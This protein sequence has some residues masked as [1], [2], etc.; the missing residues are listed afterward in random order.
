MPRLTLATGAIVAALSAT[1]T[2]SAHAESQPQSLLELWKRIPPTP[3]TLEAANAMVNDAQEIPAITALLADLDAHGAA[4]SQTAT[5]ADA[6]IHERMTGGKSPE[7]AAAGAA[8]AAGIDVQRMQTDPAYAKEMEAKMRAMS[9]AELMA[10][11]SAMAQSMGMHATVAVYDPPEV[12]AAA[13]AGQAMM[14]PT[15]TTARLEAYTTRWLEVEK[16]TTAVNDAYAARYPKMSIG[17][18]GEGGGSP[19]CIAAR[20][21]YEAEMMPLLLARDAEVLKLEAV[22]LEQERTALAERVAAADAHLTAAQYGANSQELGNPMQILFLDQM[23]VEDMRTLTTR[24]AEVT[25]RAAYITHCG[26]TYLTNP[27]DCY[28]RQ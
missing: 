16:A 22:A 2:L 18:D 20:A 28:K 6:K 3:A 27:T 13:E 23:M 19:E 14:D 12:K 8:N 4:V 15:A 26:K 24:L 9:P 10:L 25:K 7:Q 21:R 11:S 17:C 1:C 5:A